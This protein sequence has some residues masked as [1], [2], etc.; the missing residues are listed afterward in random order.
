M[1]IKTIEDLKKPQFV[2]SDVMVATGRAAATI[3]TWVNRGIF[4]PA[5]GQNPGYGQR[6]QYSAI[7]VCKIAVL[8]QLT[9]FGFPPSDA[10]KVLEY[11][12]KFLGDCYGDESADE[13]SRAVILWIY[14]QPKSGSYEIQP[15]YREFVYTLAEP[16][17]LLLPLGM[18]LTLT[19]RE[20]ERVLGDGTELTECTIIDAEGTHRKQ[21]LPSV[22]IE[23]TVHRGGRK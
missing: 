1:P 23:G 19:L 7:D 18:I 2:N 10:K 4:I 3:Q 13:K 17:S 21:L 22:R 11:V 16:I 6:R 8:G 20:L 5:S 14:K 15:V 9:D 12:E